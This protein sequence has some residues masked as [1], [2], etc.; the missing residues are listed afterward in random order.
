MAHN[1]GVEPVREFLR[2]GGRTIPTDGSGK[3]ATRFLIL[4]GYN[5]NQF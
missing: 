2:S 3:D 5:L 4:G 1:V